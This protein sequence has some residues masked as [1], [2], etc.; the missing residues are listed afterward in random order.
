MEILI[1]HRIPYHKIDYHRGID[2]NLHE[3][4][5]IGTE[6]ALTNIPEFVN[7][8]KLIR[9]G[10]GK[11]ADE[12]VEIIEQQQLQFDRIISLSEYELLDAAKIR[13]HF[14]IP[15]STLG[16][17]EKV[18]NKVIMKAIVAAAGIRVPE[19]LPLSKI[20]QLPKWQDQVVVKPID[21]ASSENVKVFASIHSLLLALHAQNTGIDLLDQENPNL[22]QFEVEEFIQGP[23]VHFDGLVQDGEVKIVLASQ[24]VGDCLGYANGLPLGSVQVDISDADKVWVSRV[25]S[26]VELNNGSFHL[27]AI[28]NKNGLVFLEVA[29][30]VGGADVVDTFNLA[31]NIHLPSAELKI[32]LGED[33]EFPATTNTGKK[34]GWYVFPG[35]HYQADY[36]RISGHEKFRNHPYVVRWNELSTEQKLPQHITYQAI[37]IPLAGVIGSDSSESLQSF[38]KEMFAQVNIEPIKSSV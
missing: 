30:R 22:T 5:Y 1:L 25:L 24:Y 13:E 11:T 38:L 15:G 3:V 7:C 12:V 18:R 17:V 21:G 32:W 2:H 34:F 10:V 27:E 31:T 37:E 6:K 4:T 28:A 36:C 8:K 33:F 35:H 9:P 23:I 29:N 14:G 16:Q 20:E 26:A 19:F